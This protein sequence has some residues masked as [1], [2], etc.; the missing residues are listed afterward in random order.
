VEAGIDMTSQGPR[1]FIFDTVLRG[2]SAQTQGLAVA[3][4]TPYE[5]G[6]VTGE[7]VVL[8]GMGA[9]GQATK[10]TYTIF[11]HDR[12]VVLTAMIQNAAIAE[13]DPSTQAEYT[14]LLDSYQYPAA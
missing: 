10:V 1:D 8:T 6:G 3:S 14:A 2:L 4:T 7:Q 11:L 13:S 9:D 5:K 12:L